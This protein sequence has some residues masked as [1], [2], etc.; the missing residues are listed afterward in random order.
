MSSPAARV[1]DIARSF[2]PACVL[3]AA[4]DLDVF[5]VLASR[6][7]NAEEVAS[8]I[9]GDVRATTIL[10]DALVALE[11]LSKQGDTYALPAE[12]VDVLTDKSPQT[13]LPMVLHQANCLR[14]WVQ[15]PQVVRS[16]RPAERIPSIRGEAAD[17]ASFIG[18]MHA[19]SGPVADTVVGRLGPLSFQCLLDVGGAS[20]TWTMAFLR[21]V[22][23]AR[24]I[25]FDLP[26][27]IPMARQRLTDA[28]FIDRVD[29][30]AGNFETDPLPTGADFVWLSAIAHQNSREQN[31]A[32]FGKI[33]DALAPGGTLAIRDIVMDEDHVHPPGGALFA[34]NMLVGTERG[35]TFSL[36]E[37][38]ADL[39]AAGFGNVELV[40]RD[41]WMD[42]LIRA[43]RK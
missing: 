20:G 43:T 27:V 37:Y 32:L 30:V 23:S 13:V 1:L 41:A 31:R 4:A 14:R 12:L 21:R 16:G 6:P 33:R 39:E 15:L 10:L 17:T 28:G 5:N 22:P 18:A 11:L 34:V 2:Q 42:S 40:Y 8:A 26:D 19:I 7:M 29:L 35:G 3:A 36:E 25:I 38:K 9:R 24:A